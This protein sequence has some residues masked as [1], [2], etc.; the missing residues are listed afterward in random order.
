MPSSHKKSPW[1]SPLVIRLVLGVTFIWAGYSKSFLTSTF[2]PEAAATLAN[3][4]LSNS[5]PTPE[6]PQTPADEGDTLN[7][8]R[9]PGGE[10]PTVE[11][12]IIETP[13]TVPPVDPVDPEAPVEDPADEPLSDPVTSADRVVHMAAMQGALSATAEDFPDGVEAPRWQGLVLLMHKSGRRQLNESGN[14]VGIVVVPPAVAD[15]GTVLEILARVA[16]YTEFVAG[17]MLILGLFSRLWALAVVG[18]MLTAAW[19]TMIG[20][21]VMHPDALLGFLPSGFTDA[22]GTPGHGKWSTFMLQMANLAMGLAVLMIGP[23]CLSVDAKLFPRKAAPA[24][25]P[26]RNELP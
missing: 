9:V 1:F 22:P 26:T 6:Q 16:A 4:G 8:A 11:I 7:D 15:N 21:N 13:E 2:P 25:K 24:K 23:G 3:L 5:A 19:L 12:P 10:P 18:I 20:P 14:P 17:V